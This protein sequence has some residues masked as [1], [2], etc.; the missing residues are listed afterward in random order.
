[1]TANKGKPLATAIAN[2][3]L[4]GVVVNELASGAYLVSSCRWCQNRYVP[5]LADLVVLSRRICEVQ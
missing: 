2:L 3:A 5:T 1:M 4:A